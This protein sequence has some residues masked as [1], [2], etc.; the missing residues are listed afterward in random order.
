MPSTTIQQSVRSRRKLADLS[1]RS[2]C[3]LPRLQPNS[4]LPEFGHIWTGRSR[5]NPTSAGGVGRGYASAN[6][7]VCLLPVPPPQAGEGNA[8][9]LPRHMKPKAREL[10]ALTPDFPPSPSGLPFLPPLSHP[11]TTP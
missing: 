10:R 2:V 8:P 4:G 3:S 9:S 5:I 6:L 1:A 7:S 11:P